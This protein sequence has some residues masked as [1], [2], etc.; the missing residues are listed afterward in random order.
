MIKFRS[1]EKYCSKID[2]IRF[3][4]K[5]ILIIFIISC[6]LLN[7]SLANGQEPI[8]FLTGKWAGT[9]SY[10]VTSNGFTS[11]TDSII[12][13]ILEQSFFEFKGN[14]ESKSNGKKT[15]WVFEGYLGERGRNI[16]FINQNNK[17]MLVGYIIN[18]MNNNLIK[19]YNW[20]DKNKRAIVYILKK[21][22]S[23]DNFKKQ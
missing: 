22:E 2:L 8:P 13:N 11:S 19:L 17:K 18:Q 7:N 16:C 10:Q 14:A 9:A 15:L 21:I 20:D 4:K 5:Y 1:K 23:A 12:L 6:S 3:S